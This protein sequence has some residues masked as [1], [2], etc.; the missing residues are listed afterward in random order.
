MMKSQAFIEA[1]NAEEVKLR[2]RGQSFTMPRSCLPAD[3]QEA[4]VIDVVI[5]VN[6]AETR[7]R[8]NKVRRMLV[9][10]GM[11]ASFDAEAKTVEKEEGA[12]RR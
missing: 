6:E 7:R 12:L 2:M 10:S 9:M 8:I 4:D 1:I 5:F 3:A 11:L